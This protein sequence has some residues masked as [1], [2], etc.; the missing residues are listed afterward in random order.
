[1]SIG[2]T[3][4]QNLTLDSFHE[5]W[6]NH[7]APLVVSVAGILGIRRYI[8]L[9]PLDGAEGFRVPADPKFDG[10]AQIDFD[11][12]EDITKGHR[13][14]QAQAAL[15]QLA[16]DEA[17]FIDREKSVRWWGRIEVVI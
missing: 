10:V 5:H 6:R 3:R 4:L 12:I 17:R 2:L 11:S 16:E 8:Q 13:T 15:R 7:H 14:E 1:M 9:L